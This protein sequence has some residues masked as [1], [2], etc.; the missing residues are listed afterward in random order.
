MWLLAAMILASFKQSDAK[1]FRRE[2]NIF[3]YINRILNPEGKL[4][5][6]SRRH[7]KA[8]HKISYNNWSQAAVCIDSKA[9]IYKKWNSNIML[10]H[11]FKELWGATFLYKTVNKK[12]A[13]GKWAQIR[14]LGWDNE[15]ALRGYI[16]KR[17]LIFS[18][19]A[20]D[21]FEPILLNG[22]SE[23]TVRKS[24]S[25]KAIPFKYKTGDNNFHVY[26]KPVRDNDSGKIFRLIS[27][28]CKIYDEDCQCKPNT[29]IGWVKEDMFSRDNLTIRSDNESTTGLETPESEEFYQ[30]EGIRAAK[31]KKHVVTENSNNPEKKETF[32]SIKTNTVS[33]DRKKL[34]KLV[35]LLSNLIRVK[36]ANTPR[37]WPKT[38]TEIFG[39]DAVFD[40]ENGT[41]AEIIEEYLHVPVE[42]NLLKS[43]FSGISALSPVKYSELI[44]YLTKK[45]YMLRAVINEKEIK[46]GID[47]AGNTIYN[48]IGVKKYWQGTPR[49]EFVLLE[50][51]VYLP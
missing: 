19:S 15:P 7:N 31:I 32:K 44:N 38:F 47:E 35:A 43:R 20:L 2:G 45:L 10:K 41:P 8:P 34:E 27:K 39:A 6:K 22:L 12:A 24:P 21:S 16:E 13:K 33:L 42:S 30:G 9:K 51:E 46:L 28:D 49:F 1:E 23:I 3:Q 40:S 18:K 4:R 25:V 14:S 11:G 50:T 48:D 26:I 36:Q 37:M 29:I 5:P 17:F